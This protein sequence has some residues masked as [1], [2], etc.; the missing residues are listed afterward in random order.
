MK[1]MD[2]TQLAALVEASKLLNGTLDHDGVLWRLMI[3]AARG[4]D[5]DRATLY[6]LDKARRELRFTIALDASLRGMCLPMEE[7]LV[8]YV[9]RTG[10]VV[11]IEDAYADPRFSHRFDVETG[12]HTHT[13]LTVPLRDSQGEILGVV[14]ALN[15]QQGLFSEADERYL[16]ALTEHTAVALENVRQHAALTAEYQWLSF[17]NRISRLMTGGDPPGEIRLHDVL[18]TVMGGAVDVLEVEA[19]SILLWNRQRQRLVFVTSTHADKQELT[20]IEAPLEGS[21]AGWVIRNE[22]AV[23]IN[24]V[25]SDP[26]YFAGIEERTG[27]VIRTMVCVPMKV[28]GK[29]VGVLQMLNKRGGAEFREVDLELAQ[30]VANH[31]ALAIESA[32]HYE[33]LL[34]VGE[35]Q[36]MWAD[37]GLLDSA[38][39][40]RG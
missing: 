31:A 36:E 14:Q 3:L 13:V 30:A 24:D 9:A 27:F 7:G 19:C 18:L 23:I 11:N 34:R 6:V 40:S 20:E 35:Y 26:R 4:T 15:K 38:G 33:S 29:V 37:A 16:L 10:E 22:Q 39:R 5:A 28:R 12:Y 21:I 2:Q 25:H 1:G 17:L 32:R 8:G